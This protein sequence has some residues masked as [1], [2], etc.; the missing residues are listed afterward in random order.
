MLDIICRFSLYD[1]LEHSAILNKYNFKKVRD[2]IKHIVMWKLKE[3]AE[4]KS[5]SE[6]ARILKMRLESLRNSIVQIRFIEVG[7]NINP[8]EDS[9]DVVLYSEF[10]NIGDLLLYQNHPD[11]MKISEFVSKV[12]DERVVT[13]YEV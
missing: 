7:I 9:C 5:K 11:H 4:G 3:F 13:D 8:L 1:I 2:L 10:D 12:R 6:N